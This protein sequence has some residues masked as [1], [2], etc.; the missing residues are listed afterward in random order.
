MDER[1][2]NQN[3]IR[4]LHLPYPGKLKKWMKSLRYQIFL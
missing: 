2:G 4:S 1:K 3:I